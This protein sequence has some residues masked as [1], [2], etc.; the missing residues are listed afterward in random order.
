MYPGFLE[1]VHSLQKAGLLISVV[2]NFSFSK[3]IYKKFF[4]ISGD[5]LRSFSVS[6]HREKVDRREF[7][8]KCLWAKKKLAKT[9]RGSLVVNSVVEPGRA[10][11]LV[12]IKTAFKDRGIRFYPQLKRQ[13]GRPVN[14]DAAEQAVILELAED[15]NPFAIN[16]G[17]E[18]KGRACYAGINYFVVTPGGECFTC[19]P[20]K[21]DGSGYLGS[22]PGGDFVFRGE[23]VGCPYEVCP[24]TVPINRGMIV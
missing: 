17:Y 3:K 22:I 12:E 6:L 7:L 20:G 18:M 11:E 10:A 4:K 1:I 24:C 13:K 9:V 8:K 16:A 21:R 2:T 5:S 19:Y 23:P 14:Y 15:R